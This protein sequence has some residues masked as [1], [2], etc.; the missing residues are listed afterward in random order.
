VAQGGAHHPISR[1]YTEQVEP[2]LACAVYEI[3]DADL[4]RFVDLPFRT[5]SRPE[6]ENHNDNC[7][8]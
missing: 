8:S 6:W 1:K 3:E 2:P 5:T 7:G 4:E